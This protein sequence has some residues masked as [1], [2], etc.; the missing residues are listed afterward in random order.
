MDSKEIPT[1]SSS[2]RAWAAIFS[3][4]RS[5]ADSVTTGERCLRN[6]NL[7]TVEAATLGSRA[8]VLPVAVR[9]RIISDFRL[10]VRR[11]GFWL[12]IVCAL[13]VKLLL[14]FAIFG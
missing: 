9:S 12:F 6:K 8:G 2:S 4:P 1:R 5:N 11:W 7:S 3:L 13:T 10:Q 14:I